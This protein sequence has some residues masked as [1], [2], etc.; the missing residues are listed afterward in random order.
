MPQAAS[1]ALNE[2]LRIVAIE[3]SGF[4]PSRFDIQ[5]FC[6]AAPRPSPHAL[7]TVS[8]NRAL[9]RARAMSAFNWASGPC[10]SSARL[11][12]VFDCNLGRGGCLAQRLGTAVRLPWSAAPSNKHYACYEQV[13]GG[14]IAVSVSRHPYC[15]RQRIVR[16]FPMP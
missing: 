16:T 2:S 13:P 3:S 14:R 6:G 8:S 10:A 7:A 4:G 5:S 1:T 15:P 9:L 12:S 11:R